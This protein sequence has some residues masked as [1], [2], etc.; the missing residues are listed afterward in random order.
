MACTERACRGNTE[1]A[2]VVAVFSPAT[3]RSVQVRGGKELQNRPCAQNHGLR[4]LPAQ[5]SRDKRT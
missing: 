4:Q 2:Q 1:N 5:H 3:T